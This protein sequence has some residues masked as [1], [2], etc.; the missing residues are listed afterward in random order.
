MY[1]VTLNAAYQ[2]QVIKFRT[3]ADAIEFFE[4][5]TN[6]GYTVSMDGNYYFEAG[7]L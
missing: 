2:N 4:L 3:V 1:E 7:R 6:N 5:L